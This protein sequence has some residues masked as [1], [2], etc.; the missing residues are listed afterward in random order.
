FDTAGAIL[1]RQEERGPATSWRVQDRAEL[2]L[3]QDRHGEAIAALEAGL[4]AFAGDVMLRATLGFV[5]QQAGQGEAA[6]ADLALALREAQ[7]VPLAQRHA[8]LLLEL[9]RPGP[10]RAALDAIETPL[11]EE[12]V[13]SSLA[14]QRSEAAY[15]LG[16]RAGALAEARR[17]GTPFFDRLADRLESP[18]GERRVQ[19]PVPF[20]RQHHR[21]CAPATLAAIA[22]HWGQP[23]A[24]LEIA[25]AIC[26]D[27]TPDHAKRRWADEHGWRAREFTVTWAA[28]RELLERGVPFALTTVEAHAA[29]LQAVVGFDEARGTLLIRDPTIPV[30][31]EADAGAL[32]EH[33][34][35]VGPR[36]MAMVPAA[37]AARL[38]ELTLPDAELHDL[39]Y[40]L[41]QA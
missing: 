2:W 10:A 18:A 22:Q 28:A 27:G 29:H 33:Y 19:L 32:F 37:E 15:L 41:Q 36:G 30:L 26:Y 40:E 23:A 6:L 9:E 4:E 12:A 5:R 7:S 31:L 21:T 38:D 35:S 17:V 20:V 3:A 39:V 24:H 11:L 13:R 8:G 34:R 1:G 14:A 16:D 25:D